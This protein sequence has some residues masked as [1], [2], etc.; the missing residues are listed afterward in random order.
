VARAAG[1]PGPTS[2]SK[3]VRVTWLR[4]R[5]RAAGGNPDDGTTITMSARAATEN[6]S[7]LRSSQQRVAQ[8]QGGA[9]GRTDGQLRAEDRGDRGGSA[10]VAVCPAPPAASTAAPAALRPIPFYA[11]AN[12]GP[13]VMRVFLPRAPGDESAG[14]PADPG[15]SGR[16]ARAASAASRARVSAVSAP[17]RW[18][19]S[20]PLAVTPD[21]QSMAGG[22]FQIRTQD[23][24]V[25]SYP[26]AQTLRVSVRRDDGA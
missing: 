24:I 3:E 8:G 15:A 7:R 6:Q 9:D 14:P 21:R 20:R 13:A 19:S 12:R 4:P 16:I 25:Y 23:W 18:P 26:F 10:R 1:G 17:T 2:A 22:I 11:R 5:S